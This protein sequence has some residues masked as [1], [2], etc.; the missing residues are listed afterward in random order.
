MRKGRYKKIIAE[1]IFEKS[2]NTH[3]QSTTRNYGRNKFLQ[4][5]KRSVQKIECGKACC[6]EF[7]MENQ[8]RK[9]P[10]NKLNRVINDKYRSNLELVCLFVKSHDE[11]M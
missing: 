1:A 6:G 2:K 9:V 3:L 5:T 8:L 11:D 7:V 4:I 10:T